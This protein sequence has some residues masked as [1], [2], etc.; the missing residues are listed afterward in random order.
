MEWSDFTQKDIFL[1]PD[2]PELAYY[3]RKDE[4]KSSVY[5]G[6]LKLLLTLIQFL[7]LFWKPSTNPKP[8]VVYAGAAPGS[9]IAIVSE[10]LF[11][12]IEFHLYDP[13]PFKIKES[14][15]IK[16]YQQYFTDDD[17]KKWANRTDVLF[18]SDI[19]SVSHEK[20]TN[21]DDYEAAIQTDM[22]RQ[23]DWFLLINPVA[24]HLKLRFPYTGGNRP[25][26]VDYLYGHVFKQIFP[27]LTSTET[28]LVPTRDA[29]GNWLFAKWS[30]QRYQDQMFYHNVV[31]RE[32]NKYFNPFTND[33]TTIDGSELLNDWDSRAMTQILMDYLTKRSAQVTQEST[34]ALGRL[35]VSKLSRK[36]S[37]PTTL[38]SIRATPRRPKNVSTREDIDMHKSK[39]NRSGNKSNNIV[40]VFEPKPAKTGSLAADIGL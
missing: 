4:D 9:N 11:P 19:R 14:N 31:I 7:N 34:A 26:Y 29:D 39:Y 33:K 40:P 28:R 25:E 35:L 2:D 24:G 32:K 16:L 18:I 30:S 12:E 1:N 3:R 15:Q 37:K 20:V 8:V 23:M 10:L 38:S 36:S 6:Q 5:Y 22:K 21:L 27:P 17:A 13:A